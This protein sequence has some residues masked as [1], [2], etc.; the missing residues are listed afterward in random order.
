MSKGLIDLLPRSR[1]DGLS[2]IDL[3]FKILNAM[4]KLSAKDRQILEREAKILAL[5]RE[6]F[7]RDGYHGLNM[8]KIAESL[9]Y[10]KGTIYNHFPNKEEILVAL[11]IE[12]MSQRLRLF[13]RAVQFKGNPRE[14]MQAVGVAAELFARL[15]PD[16]FIIEHTFRLTTV[17]DKV[18]HWRRE[19][20][21][22][23]E[24]SCM[25]L[26][27]TLVTQGLE[28]GHIQLHDG[29]TSEDVVF[30]FWSLTSGAYA[31]ANSNPNL[32]NMGIRNPFNTVRLLTRGLADGLNWRPLSTETDYD[33]ITEKIL[34]E[35]F[36]EEL[37]QLATHVLTH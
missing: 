16:H 13:E 2:K 20:T 19:K 22:Q 34:Q 27:T 4:T 10:S 11:G 33:A 29:F 15:H 21:E 32:I 3:S 23:S 8:D 36:A 30:G 9:D 17:W 26:I 24:L 14:K 12:T 25:R 35:L 18:S 31:L 28:K 1:F 7:V 37:M 5:A 6:I